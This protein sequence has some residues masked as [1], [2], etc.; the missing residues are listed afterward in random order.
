[1]IINSPFAVC[2]NLKSSLSRHSCQ[3]C[4][5]VSRFRSLIREITSN[6]ESRDIYSDKRQEIANSLLEKITQELY[7]LGFIVES[8]LLRDISLPRN[9]Q[10][11]IQEKLKAEQESQR[12]QFELEKARQEAERKKIEAQGIANA[13]KLLSQG[14]TEEVLKLKAIEA[15]EKLAASPNTKVIIIGGG[16][17]RLPLILQQGE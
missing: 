9:I 3:N 16:E 11:A 14:L 6:Y 7:P 17:D 10:E 1:M 13:Q 5:S 2:S 12:M 4:S 15:T 8:A